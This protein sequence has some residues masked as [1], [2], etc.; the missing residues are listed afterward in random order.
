MSDKQDMDVWMIIAWT[1]GLLAA[2]ILVGLLVSCLLV[3]IVFCDQLCGV[4]LC[5]E[6]C[7]ARCCAVYC[8]MCCH[9]L[10]GTFRPMLPT[11]ITTQLEPG[12]SIDE[13]TAIHPL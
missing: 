1:F 5:S 12:T 9:R 8:C 4:Y 6:V 11:F 13:T 3:L 7:C 2:A 10:D